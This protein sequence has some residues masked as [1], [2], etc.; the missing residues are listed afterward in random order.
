M[1]QQS[2]SKGFAILSV[3]T[4]LIKVLALVYLPVQAAVMHD[5]GNGIIAAGMTLYMMI[6]SVTNVG[7]PSI[8][9]KMVAER[10]ALGDYRCTQRILRVA[11]VMLG[12][13][14]VAATLFT[15]FGA[16]AL[17]AYAA[18]PTEAVLMF[19]VIAPTLLFS[20]V[21]C[22]LRGYFQG[23]R[24]MVPT[25]IAQLIEQV[26]N[27]I[28]T[29]LFVWLLYRIAQHAGADLH[30]SYSFGAAG[31]AVG[32]VVGAIGSAL[33]LGY[34]F[35]V[36]MRKQRHKELQEQ[37]YDGP[38]LDSRTI[39]QEI[40]RYAVPALIGS[41][42][43]N[44]ANMIDTYTCI[45]SMQWGGMAN[46][47]ASSLYGIYTTQ[48]GRLF[49]VAIGFTNPLVFT[50]VPAVAAALA[51]GNRKLFRHRLAESYKLVYLLMIPIISGMMFLAKPSIT[52]IFFHRN[53]GSDLLV[54]GVWTAVLSV[55]AAV[56]GGLL[57]AGGAPLAGPVNTIIGMGPKIL[58]NLLLVPI[59]SV[60]VKGAIIGNAVG[61]LVTIVLNDRVARKRLGVGSCGLR[62]LRAPVFGAAVMGGA[63]WLIYH[64]LYTPFAPRRAGEMNIA[65]SDVSLL[66]T[67]AAGIFI[68]FSVMIKIGGVS[69]EDIAK[70]PMG[71]RLLRLLRKVPFLRK[72]LQPKPMAQEGGNGR[73]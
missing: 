15:Y 17:A 8:V 35:T 41:I 19:K 64:A 16:G 48:Y 57:I 42:A 1:K 30:T 22:A 38:T 5:Y 4:M 71:G 14:G 49:T 20:C 69:A 58:C 44:A 32:T 40:L 25:A 7:L 52:L 51:V 70:L 55:I 37:T 59:H 21:S 9:S 31:S 12:V 10:S 18:F 54:F 63:C 3:S 34:L 66:I 28:F 45:R 11:S 39:F 50:M 72:N 68:Y 62:S 73:D 53:N 13:L 29:A 43:A 67:V 23:R 47:L 65:A 46:D 2:T 60:N 27:T 24:N 56:Q 26:L 33:F 61:W 36:V 6:Y